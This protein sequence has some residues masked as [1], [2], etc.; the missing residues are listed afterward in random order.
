MQSAMDRLAGFLERH[1]W[2]VLG[3]WLV[4]LVGAAPFVLVPA[5]MELMGKWNWWLPKPLA[6]I[7]PSTA[8]E[9]S[10]YEAGGAAVRT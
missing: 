3:A 6:R 2:L 1:R 4:L 8:F 5:T 7:L 10:G 9:S